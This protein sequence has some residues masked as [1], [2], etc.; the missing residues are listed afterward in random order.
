VRS[1]VTCQPGRLRMLLAAH[2][3]RRW[4][5]G[6]LFTASKCVVSQ[7][8]RVPPCHVPPRHHSQNLKKTKKQVQL[9]SVRVR[10]EYS[11]LS[12]QLLTI[13]RAFYLNDAAAPP[14]NWGATVLIGWL[15]G[16]TLHVGVS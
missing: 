7:A 16:R 5:K 2:T 3:L 15:L 8:R 4:R 11:Y 6:G 13:W 10:I 1:S 12:C 9:Y 14:R